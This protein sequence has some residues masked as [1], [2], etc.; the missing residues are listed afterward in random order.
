MELTEPTDL[1]AVDGLEQ[2]T[3]SETAIDRLVM[4]QQSKDII[5]AI[6]KTYTFSRESGRFSADFILGKGE[7]Q[8]I[9]LHGPPGTGKT[10]T[11]GMY[12]YICYSWRTNGL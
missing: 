1:V 12:H 9:L 5:K 7:G 10:F 11:A 8:I 6:A 2:P 3:L 4:N